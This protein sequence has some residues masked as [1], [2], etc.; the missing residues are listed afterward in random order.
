MRAL[1]HPDVES[2]DLPTLL[3][4]LADPVRLSVVRQLSASGGVVCGGFDALSM[5]GMSTLSHHLK[6]LREAGILRVVPDGRTRRHE[7][8]TDELGARFPGLLTAVLGHLD[9]VA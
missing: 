1:H 6:I 4:A 7:L 3:H 2:V 5:V 9:K 8:R